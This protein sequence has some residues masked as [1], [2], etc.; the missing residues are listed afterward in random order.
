MD[1][2][3]DFADMFDDADDVLIDDVSVKAMIA[4]PGVIQEPFYGD[5]GGDPDTP[6]VIVQKN[7]LITY[8]LWPVTDP[9]IEVDEII[10]RVIRVHENAGH[11]QLFLQEA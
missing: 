4:N 10:Y 6:F 7:D 5:D 9:E 8:D 1:F 3:D 11:V 2:Q